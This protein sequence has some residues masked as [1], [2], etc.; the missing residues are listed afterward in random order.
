MARNQRPVEG[1]GEA[2]DLQQQ[3]GAPPGVGTRVAQSSGI[4]P[5][6]PQGG[7]SGSPEETAHTNP[8]LVQAA[9]VVGSA[10]R[11]GAA[12]GPSVR[13][14]VVEQ[15]GPIMHR[16]SRGTLRAGKQINE[17]NYDIPSLRSQGIRLREIREDEKFKGEGAAP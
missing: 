4:R 10:V 16:G 7:A 15:G 9:P 11:E 3:G 14:Y 6:K 13:T 8:S 12:K 5:A 1:E 17:A 2:A